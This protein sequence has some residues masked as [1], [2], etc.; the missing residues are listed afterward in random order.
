MFERIADL[1]F[2]SVR[3]VCLCLNGELKLETDVYEITNN[4]RNLRI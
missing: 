4:I 2:P 1:R 3:F